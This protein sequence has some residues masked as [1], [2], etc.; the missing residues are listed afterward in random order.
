MDVVRHWRAVLL[1]VLLLVVFARKK[2]P[3]PVPARP[4]PVDAWA[5]AHACTGKSPGFKTSAKQYY[6]ELVDIFRLYVHRKK[7]PFPQKTTDD[8]VLQLRE[9]KTPEQYSISWLKH[10]G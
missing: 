2:K 7:S 4:L 8:L 10:S 5:E 9:L 6:A 3:A 1:L